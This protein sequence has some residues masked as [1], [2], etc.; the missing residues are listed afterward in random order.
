MAL[1]SVSRRQ[2][3]AHFRFDRTDIWNFTWVESSAETFPTKWKVPSLISPWMTENPSINGIKTENNIFN[4][5]I[6]PA[7][8]EV[9]VVYSYMSICKTKE[10]SNVGPN[11]FIRSR[12][13]TSM[14]MLKHWINKHCINLSRCFR[15][16]DAHWLNYL[17]FFRINVTLSET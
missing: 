12:L 8:F 10:F 17:T 5:C 11:T 3:A 1:Q 13:W 2:C 9:C 14:S 15:W 7:N 6:F 4:F 16:D